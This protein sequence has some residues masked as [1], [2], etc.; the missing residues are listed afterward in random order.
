MTS[1]VDRIFEKNRNPCFIIAELGNNH[2]GSK[3]LALQ[4][5]DEAILAGVD[6]VKLQMRNL[7]ELYGSMHKKDR[8]SADLGA[9]YT[10]DLLSRFQLSN[11]EMNEVFDYCKSKGILAFCTPWDQSSVAALESYGVELYKVASAD[12]TNHGLLRSLA[13]TGKP[14]ICSTGMSKQLEIKGASDL[15][16]KLGARFAFLHCN[17]TYPAPFKDI[18]LSYMLS[19]KQ[20]APVIGYSGHERGFHI[21][22]AAVAMGAKIIEKHFTLD[23]KMEGVDH[24]VSLLP[25]EM[26]QMVEQIRELELALGPEASIDRTLSQGELMNRENL[27]KSLTAKQDIAKGQTITDPMIEIRSPGQ[28]LPPYQIEEIVGRP[29]KRDFAAG[30]V[31]FD[32]DLPDRKAVGA[33]AFK[34]R[35]PWGVPVRYHDADKFLKVV[36]PD[37]FEFHLSYGDMLEN[38]SKFL[39]G[40]YK[41][42]GFTVH[43]PELF[44]G[45][46]LLDLCSNRPQYLQT[47]IDNMRRVIDLAVALKDFFPST[48][49]PFIVTTVG[50]F[51]EHA[52]LLPAA[53]LP[54]Y[55]KIFESLQKMASPEVEILPQTAA[56]F[57]WHMGGQQYQNLF[58]MPDEIAKFCGARGYRMCLDIS[59]SYLACNHYDIDPEYFFNTVGPHSAHVHVGDSRGVDGEGIQIGEG[60]VNF[61]MLTSVL[62]K[63]C[64]NAWFIPEIWQ[65]HKNLGEGFWVALEK[66]EGT[67]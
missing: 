29:A 2:N 66:L 11:L 51:T 37:F 55:D 17:S 8:A 36:K 14:I 4:L 52:P 26:R 61:A 24:K 62:N 10:L 60:E 13:M 65:G 6:A 35:R 1:V 18:N 22:I 28:G 58:V 54:L 23:K 39:K 63:A 57:P 38:P 46:H 33:R 9:Q 43:A 40:D 49:R 56:P 44:E 30:D 50:G 16:K 15:L 27:G 32:S 45:D 64:P 20:F 67:L 12:L 21:C 7:D 31:F 47:S 25:S 19:L 5:V 41:D 42:I 34:F 59:H 3:N 53:R 48:K